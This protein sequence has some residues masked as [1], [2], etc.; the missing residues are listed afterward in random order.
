MVIDCI[1]VTLK[2]V[3]TVNYEANNAFSNMDYHGIMWILFFIPSV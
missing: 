2:I 3:S 1:Y